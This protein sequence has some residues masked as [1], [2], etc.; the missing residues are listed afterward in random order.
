QAD[1]TRSQLSGLASLWRVVLD[2][3][4]DD[5]QL[6]DVSSAL[7]R[8]VALRLADP[9]VLAAARLWCFV[10]VCHPQ[11]ASRMVAPGECQGIGAE[12]CRLVGHNRVKTLL[13]ADHVCHALPTEE[14]I[15]VLAELFPK[16]LVRE[17]AAL[18]R[19]DS[20]IGLRLEHVLVGSQRQAH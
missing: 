8:D 20:N 2:R 10:A 4:A 3:M 11:R 18:V 6:S 13:A 9:A 12:A 19:G 14:G 5:E 1:A 17:V 7:R 16:S 15:S